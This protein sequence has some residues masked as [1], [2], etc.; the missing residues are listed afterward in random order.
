MSAKSLR[1]RR[2]TE[3]GPLDT[4]RRCR[5]E[6]PPGV[7]SWKSADDLECIACQVET[8]TYVKI[9]YTEK[10]A[11]ARERTAARRST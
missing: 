1:P 11:R 3:I 9:D 5:E 7:I 6:W 10:N 8:G 2:Y 4:C